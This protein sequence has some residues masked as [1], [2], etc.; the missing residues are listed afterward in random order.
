[1]QQVS[2]SEKL[3]TVLAQQEN[4]DDS[5]AVQLLEAQLSHSDGIRGFFVTYLTAL[6]GD[7]PADWET[8]PTALEKAMKG[9]DATDLIPLACMNVV[10]PTGMI[11]MHKEE[12]LAQQS[13]TTAERGLRVLQT[14]LSHGNTRAQCR[15]ILA[16]A[17]GT[18]A[19]GEQQVAK[20]VDEKLFAYWTEFFDKWGYKE[21]QKRD[22][23]QAMMSVLET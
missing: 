22:I 3:V 4:V 10:M 1:M 2:H 5:L 23:A 21:L 6:D 8:V 11:T 20:D 7:S 17:R 18:S 16:V 12:E 14:L 15:A 9:A 19:S 13:Q